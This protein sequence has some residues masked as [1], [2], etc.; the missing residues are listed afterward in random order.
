MAQPDKRAA[1]I[2]IAL[3]LTASITA[4]NL[5]FGHTSAQKPIELIHASLIRADT[6]TIIESM[7]EVV[8]VTYGSASGMVYLKKGNQAYPLKDKA[9][10][11]DGYQVLLGEADATPPGYVLIEIYR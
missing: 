8:I 1:L 10:K 7:N 6:P 3:I 4:A 2:T 9:V 11:I 5:I